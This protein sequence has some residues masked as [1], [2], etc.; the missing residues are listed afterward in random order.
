[1]KPNPPIHLEI[2]RKGSRAFGLL[3]STFRLGGKIMH[4]THG[5]ISSC[6]Y[7]HLKLIQAAFRHEAIPVDSPDALELLDSKEYGACAALLALAK[8][9]GLPKVLYSRPEPWVNDV[10]AMIIGRLLYAGSK[11]FLSHQSANTALWELCGVEG[12]VDVDKHCYEA[13]DRLLERQPAIQKTLAAKHLAEGQLVLYDITSSY[14][15]GEYEASELVAFGY[16][17]DRKRGHEQIVLGLLCSAEGCPVAV[18]VFPGNT[19]DASTV[20]AKID[21]LKETYG[22]KEIIFVGDRGMVTAANARLLKDVEGLHTISALTHRQIV[23]L[24]EKKTIQ[25]ELF[26]DKEI[27]EVVDPENPSRRYCLCRNPDQASRE[28][29]TR[30]ALLE[31][32]R[33]GLEQIAKNKTRLANEK[34]GARVGQLLAKTRMGKFVSW[35]MKEGR[36]EWSIDEDGVAAEK[37]WDGCYIISSDVPAE[38]L[39]RQQI[40]ASYKSLSLVEQ[41]FRNLKTVSLE[42]RPV[43]H[44]KDE[45]IKAHVFLC[46]LSYY[47]QWHA[48]QRLRPLFENDG[49]GKHRKWTVEAIIE[50]LKAIR[51][52]RVRLAGV[53]FCKIS[54]ADSEQLSILDLLKVKL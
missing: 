42:I 14:M 53:E 5:C 17:R 33:S 12:E 19:Q 7:E 35:E 25:P 26:D 9:I 24:L 4:K 31:R 49:E 18:E 48:M 6:S 8:N 3:R 40:V 44:Q 16:N 11:L 15:E 47:V 34:L 22:L 27:I 43:Y 51:Q 29:M 52:Q 46:M 36:M 28:G 54:E 10:L 41:A 45:R 50:R 2:Q 21:E 20:I 37:R 1:L 30:Q 38:R 13:L 39:T 23:A 32:T